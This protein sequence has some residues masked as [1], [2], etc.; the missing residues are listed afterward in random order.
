MSNSQV[1]KPLEEFLRIK[2]AKLVGKV[3]M[4]LEIL[5]RAAISCALRL[6]DFALPVMPTD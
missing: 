6:W 2:R 4:I 3:T 5:G 1:V